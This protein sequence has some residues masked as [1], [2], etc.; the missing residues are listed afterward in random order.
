MK[1]NIKAKSVNGV[2]WTFVENMSLSMITFVIGVIM[3]RLLMPSDYGVLAIILVFISILQLFVDGG[4]AMAL[5]Q[6]KTKGP[7]DYSTI[8][9]FNVAVSI[10]C[11]LLLFFTAPLIS[12]FYNTEITLYIRVI[13]VNLII[14]ALSAIHKVKYVADVNALSSLISG[15]VGIT[16]AYIGFGIWALIA[17]NLTSV[18]V[19]SLILVFKSK[20]H[21]VCLFDKASFKKLYPIGGRMMITNIIDRVYANLYPIIV[22][23]FYTTQEL[24]YF[25]RADGLV[26]FPASTASSVLYRVTFPVLSSIT[27]EQQLISVYRRYIQLSSFLLFPMILLMFV[28][29]KPLILILLTTKW[30]SIIVLFQILCLRN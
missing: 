26:T 16:M 6:D 13:G 8:F 21:P 11:Y 27:D 9:T 10:I 28:L 17:Q 19:S 14:G 7:R 24:G 30:A 1:N 4:F 23:K 3:A 22:G 25:S 5:V 15:G 20:W 18:A 2:I 29:A 12:M